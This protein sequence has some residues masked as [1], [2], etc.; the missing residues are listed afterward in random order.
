MIAHLAPAFSL[1]LLATLSPCVLPLYPGFLAYLAKPGGGQPGHTRYLGFLVL[2]GV[3]TMMLAL[4]GLFTLLSAL[5]GQLSA[6]VTSLGHGIIVV[7]GFALVLNVNPLA[8]LPQLM[9]LRSQQAPYLSA[10][11]YGL[12]YGPMTLPC[13]G[14]LTISLFSLSLG[15]A[16]VIEQ[17]L[18]FLIY[19]LG[20]G[21]PLMALSLLTDAS[22]QSLLPRLTRHT[23]V[24]SCASGLTLVALGLWNLWQGW[25]FFKLY[26]SM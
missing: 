10:F 1:G 4:G 16:G 9:A 13:T 5:T 22:R 19:G 3:L 15:V 14:P 17:L 25:S 18:F 23:R 2:A 11:A 24:I 20:L 12:L 7:M 21:L 8:R 26:F 6:L